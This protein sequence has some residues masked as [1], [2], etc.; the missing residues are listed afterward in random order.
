[1][2]FDYVRGARMALSVI[3]VLAVC[4]TAAAQPPDLFFVPGRNVNT[5]GPSP[6]GPNPGLA[7]NPKQKQRNEDSCDVSPQNPWV[8]LCANNDYR[9][10][11]LFGDSWIGLSMSSD[12]ART[13]RDRLLDG[14][15]SAPAGIGAA[16]PVVR[17]VPGLGLVAYITLSRTDGRG[18]LSLALLQERNKENGEPYQFFQTRVI[19]NGTPGRF[20]DKPAMIAVLDP[21]VGTLNVGGR[22]VPKGTVHFSY[23]M[24]PGNDN[25]SG[26]QIYHTYSRDY[27]LTWSSPKKLSESLGTNQGVDLAVD[28]ATNTVVATWRQ[29]ADTNQADSHRGRAL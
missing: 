26:S 11:E 18:T 13:W 7:G 23:A 24:F 21:G 2:R 17:T 14:F 22:Q 19:G 1:M 6:S 5:L 28:D 20:H 4:A 15:P 16:D 29:L 12:G 8:V 9:G 27:G 25:N 3:G 10:I